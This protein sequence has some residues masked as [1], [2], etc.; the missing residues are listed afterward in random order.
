MEALRTAILDKGKSTCPEYH[1]MLD[2]WLEQSGIQSVEELGAL[3]STEICTGFDGRVP[4]SKP[5]SAPRSET[6]Y[7]VEQA[8]ER[9]PSAPCS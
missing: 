3:T 6:D 4:T 8:S 1:R 5:G 9:P 7:Q 2:L